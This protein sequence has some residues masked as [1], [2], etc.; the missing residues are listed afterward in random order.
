MFCGGLVTALAAEPMLDTEFSLGYD[1]NVSNSEH[2]EDSHTSRFAIAAL[3]VDHSISAG[4]Q[5]ALLLRA[6]LQAEAH[7]DLT[8]LNSGKLSGMLRYTHTPSTE[9]STLSYSAWISA[10]QWEFNSTLRDSREL[11]AGAFV[12]QRVT[13]DVSARW[14]LG[15][16]KRRADSEVFDLR[17][18][19]AALDLDWHV[20]PA[21]TL[22]GGIQFQDG[23]VVSSA[24]PSPAI[25][26]AAEALAPEDVF[27]NQVAYRL[28]AKT[29]IP[30]LGF[31]CG[32][33]RSVSF[34]LQ[35]QYIDTEA[36]GDNE[37]QR[38]ITIAG[39]LARF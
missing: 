31:N 32:L 3:R 38:W 16:A 7:D 35:T 13:E 29:W 14:S 9:F 17:V 12:T 10:A 21:F 22:Y 25:R 39:L 24:S 23:D 28:E 18:L 33:S 8:G 2:N 37:Y 20:T 5:D 27:D 26:D 15:G 4:T 1:D 36:T 11:R 19:S 30:T 34:D 6:G